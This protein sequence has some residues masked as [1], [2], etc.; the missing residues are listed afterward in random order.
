MAEPIPTSE[1]DLESNESEVAL[2]T[3]LMVEP[4]MGPC[5]PL[6]TE[7]PGGK[8]PVINGHRF[9]PKLYHR[10]LP[11]GTVTRRNWLS[12]SKS[13]ERLYCIECIL[14]P[15][16]GKN[17]PNKAWVIDGYKN[18]STCTNKI[19]NHEKTSA[20]IYSSLTLKIR[21]SSLPLVPSIATKKNE[22]VFMNR[23]MI[24]ELIDIT[25]FLG[26]HN[27][28]FRGHRENW[29]NNMY[30][31]FKDLCSLI[32]K[33]SPAMATYFSYQKQKYKINQRSQYSFTS[34]RRQNALIDIVSNYI[35]SRLN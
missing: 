28:A 4:K 21:Q 14:F 2:S 18:W 7:L 11:Y 10:I 13:T 6:P 17:A 12:Y 29:Q 5:Q 19:E 33:F 23:E 20:H 8:Y 26:R 16:K 32:S 25:L 22:E 15:G 9:S 34:W 1:V 35:K 27:M 30:G 31:N 24:K 3:T